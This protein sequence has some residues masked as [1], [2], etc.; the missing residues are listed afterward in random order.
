MDSKEQFDFLLQNIR[1]LERTIEGL[2]EELKIKRPDKNYLNTKEACYLLG[3]SKTTL[4]RLMKNGEI[5]FTSVGG[6]RKF[7]RTELVEYVAKNRTYSHAK[8]FEGLR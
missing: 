7:L 1:S 3:I 8:A 5:C 4:Y 2:I 6:S